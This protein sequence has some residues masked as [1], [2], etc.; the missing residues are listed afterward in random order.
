MDRRTFIRSVVGN[1]LAVAFAVPALFA[2][3][4]PPRVNW[5]DWRGCMASIAALAFSVTAFAASY[6]VTDL[7]TLAGGGSVARGINNRGQVVGNSDGRAFLYTDGSMKDLDPQFGGNNLAYAINDLGQVVGYS[8]DIGGSLH[9]F[10]YSGGTTT[11]LSPGL[12]SAAIGINENGQIVGWV[13]DIAVAVGAIN[14]AF[15]LSGGSTAIL[16]PDTVDSYGQANAVNARGQV[17]GFIATNFSS[18][19]A[20]AA[21]IS[22]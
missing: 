4:Q 7:G 6:S 2:I 17:V 22:V 5:C 16:G 10:L 13:S 1:P 19:S 9:A 15:L 21:C 12:Q 11:N 14:H 8:Q 3:Y 18:I 20:E